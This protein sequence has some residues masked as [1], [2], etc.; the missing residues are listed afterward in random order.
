LRLP[1]GR[2]AFARKKAKKGSEE[3]SE[4]KKLTLL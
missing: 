3:K 4:E 2:Q 1:A